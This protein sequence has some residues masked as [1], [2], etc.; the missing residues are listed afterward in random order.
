MAEKRRIMK[1]FNR[2]C[3]IG[4]Q[5]PHLCAKSRHFS[6]LDLATSQ[7]A[8]NYRHFLQLA[9]SDLQ[10]WGCFVLQNFTSDTLDLD[11]FDRVLKDTCAIG[12]THFFFRFRFWTKWRWS[13]PLL[14]SFM[15]RIV[16][17]LVILPGNLLKNQRTRE[18]TW[19]K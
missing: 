4:M 16:D 14:M 17:M 3:Q 13:Q 6:N 1:Y 9:T 15:C 2:E 7:K 12:I 18:I 8:L 11:W 5:R 19:N 10:N